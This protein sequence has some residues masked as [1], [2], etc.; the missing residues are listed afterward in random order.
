[1]SDRLASCHP[2]GVQLYS[3]QFCG[4]VW[5]SVGPKSHLW[6]RSLAAPDTPTCGVRRW[7]LSC[8]SDEATEW[9]WTISELLHG[10]EEAPLL[11]SLHWKTPSTLL[12]KWWS[13]VTAGAGG[14]RKGCVFFLFFEHSPSCLSCKSVLLAGGGGNRKGKSKKW[15]Q[16]LQFPHISMCEELRQNT[17][18]GQGSRHSWVHFWAFYRQS[19]LNL[20]CVVWL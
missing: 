2:V 9:Y 17:G 12:L 19:L 6:F 4:P 3:Q 10:P 11:S 16:M 20:C 13:H 8:S 5:S 18:K 15:K 1:M 7:S 14:G